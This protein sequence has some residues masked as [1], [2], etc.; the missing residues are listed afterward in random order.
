MSNSSLRGSIA[1]LLAL[2]ALALAPPLSAQDGRDAP[3]VALAEVY[4][5]GEPLDLSAYRVSEKYDGVRAWWTGEELRTRSG[6]R[7][8]TPAWFTAGWPRVALDGELWAG[9]GRFEF[10]SGAVRKREPVDAEWRQLR[11]LVFDMPLQAGNFDARQVQLRKRAPQLGPWIT[12]V[13][14]GRVQTQVE[15][16]ARLDAIVAAGGE[17]LILRRGDAP[18]AAGRS[19]DLL[20]LKP[21]DDAE[22]IVVA[23][24]PGRGK[25]ATMTGALLVECPD[26]RRFAVGSGLSDAQ[27]RQPPPLGSTITYAYSGLTAAGV[28][29]FAR[30][31][32]VRHAP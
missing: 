28:P 19:R 32:R 7:I 10:G 15:L 9:R 4:H 12:V 29:R 13:A 23:H 26:G 21:Y 24:L 30:F 6:Q 27:R 16:A 11:Y 5:L 1:A 8:H 18:H 2:A 17:G 20:K 14:Q 3:P 22:A 31:L 25:Y